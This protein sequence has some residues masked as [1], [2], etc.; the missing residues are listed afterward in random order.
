MVAD[1][2]VSADRQGC[3]VWLPIFRCPVG[4]PAVT[5]GRESPVTS[6]DFTSVD[7]F[8]A[9]PVGKSTH[10]GTAL[11]ADGR[12]AFDKPLPNG[13]PQLRELFTRLK[14]KGKVLVVVDQPA[15]IGTL[16]VTV[17]RASGCEVAYLPGLSMRRLADLHPAPARPTPATPTSSPTPPALCPTCCT[18]SSPTRACGPNWPWSWATT[19]TSPRTPPAPPT[20]CADCSPPSVT[21][22]SADGA[23]AGT[24]LSTTSYNASGTVQGVGY[25]KAGDLAAN[26]I[27]YTC[28][29]GTLRPVKVCGPQNARV[30]VDDRGQVHPRSTDRRRLRLWWGVCSRLRRRMCAGAEW[31]DAT[32]LAAGEQLPAS[33]R[34]VVRNTAVQRWTQPATVH[35]LTVADI[36]T[37]YVLAGGSPDGPVRHAHRS[38]LPGGTTHSVGWPVREAWPP[39]GWR[40]R[41]FV[42]KRRAVTACEDWT[43]ALVPGSAPAG[44]FV[45]SEGAARGGWPSSPVGGR[46]VGRRLWVVHHGVVQANRLYLLWSGK[47]SPDSTAKHNAS[48]TLMV[49]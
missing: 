35:N 24:Y 47:T 18:P 43:V 27:V 46:P 28:E 16:A 29:D 31:V 40:L 20:G 13:E 2:S 21:I 6:N 32:N 36:H 23:L 49:S 25:P 44:D 11:L 30:H 17:A 5:P 10:H 37:H 15:S 7:V 34:A 19:T 45:R 1:G 42:M 12:T 48:R 26:N 33:T 4:P 38:A 41:R 8:C 9:L 39:R 14:R 22:P 3:V